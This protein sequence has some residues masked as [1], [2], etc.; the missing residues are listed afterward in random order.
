MNYAKTFISRIDEELHCSFKFMNDIVC[1][2]KII[3]A[4]LP[5]NQYIIKNRWEPLKFFQSNM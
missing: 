5:H 4:V 1:T 2:I 3:I